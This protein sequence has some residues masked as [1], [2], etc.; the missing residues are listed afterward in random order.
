MLSPG[1][2]IAGYVWDYA[3]GMQL[4]RRFWDAAGA[5]DPD[6][7]ALDE[8]VR[9]GNA[10]PGPLAAASPGRDWRRSRRGRS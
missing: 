3:D 9:F 6:A 8:A 7:H 1:G 4:L 5:L 2:V 10:A